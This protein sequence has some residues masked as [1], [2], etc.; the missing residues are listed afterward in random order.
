MGDLKGSEASSEAA[1]FPVLRLHVI[2]PPV[3]HSGCYVLLLT[4]LLYLKLH[5]D[6]NGR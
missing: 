5:V 4:M 6:I 3:S 1:I 2:G